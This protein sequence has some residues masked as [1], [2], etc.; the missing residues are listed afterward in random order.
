M[1]SLV[2]KIKY[3]PESSGSKVLELWDNFLLKCHY[4]YKVCDEIQ[5]TWQDKLF[6]LLALTMAGVVPL[7]IETQ[8]GKE[9]DLICNLVLIVFDVGLTDLFIFAN[10]R[11]V[12]CAIIYFGILGAFAVVTKQ[13]SHPYC[14]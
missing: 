1:P 3:T 2:Q 11:S 5:I 12:I 4:F 13:V 6:Q 9:Y 14:L 8:P 7:L 10:L